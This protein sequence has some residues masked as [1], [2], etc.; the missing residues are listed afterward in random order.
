MNIYHFQ[1]RHLLS[2]YSDVEV[3]FS[4]THSHRA[5]SFIIQQFFISLPDVS[6]LY[7][8]NKTLRKSYEVLDLKM[9]PS[10]PLQTMKICCLTCTADR[11]IIVGGYSS[12]LLI[13]K[14][15]VWRLLHNGYSC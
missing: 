1:L 6:R 7:L 14:P 9:L 11:A 13:L 12:Q 4:G 15:Q 5:V 2:H 8:W 10:I 3:C